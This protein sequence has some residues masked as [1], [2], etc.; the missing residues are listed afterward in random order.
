MDTL[1]R[2]DALAV[3]KTGTLTKGAT[4]VTSVKRYDE[5]ASQRALQLAA[6]A[7]QASFHPLAQALITYVTKQKWDNEPGHVTAVETVKGQGLVAQ[8]DG[9]PLVIGSE[10][11]LVQHGVQLSSAQQA[12]IMAAQQAGQSTVLVAVAGELQ[13]LVGIADELREDVVVSLKQLR[14]LGIKQVVMLTGDNERTAAA[15][16]QQAGVDV[17]QANL[18]PEEKVAAVQA[19]QSAGHT[20]AFVGDGINDSPSLAVADIGIAVGSGTDVAV[21]TSAVVL[22]KGSFAELVHAYGLAK[23][24]VANTR[25]NIVV[26]VATVALLLGGLVAGKIYMASGMLIHEVSILVVILNA[27]RLISRKPHKKGQKLDVRQVT[28]DTSSVH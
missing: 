4:V 26:A 20:V 7:E 23:R 19:L 24:V 11:L 2:V 6:M 3:D 8:A 21:E 9:Q 22:M 14:Q 1:S 12:D 25:E 10:A 5:K 18:L 13:V 28:G 16:G 27:M 15:I 17:V